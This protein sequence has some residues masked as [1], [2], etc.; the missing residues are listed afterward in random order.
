MAVVGQKGL[1]G[2]ALQREITEAPLVRKVAELDAIDAYQ[3]TF[4]GAKR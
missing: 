4:L 3:R 2:A 1:T